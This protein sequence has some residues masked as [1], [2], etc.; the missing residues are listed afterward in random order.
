[1]EAA[2]AAELATMTSP[3]HIR[4]VDKLASGARRPPAA[5]KEA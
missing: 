5:D 1:M 3:D 4:I 2:L